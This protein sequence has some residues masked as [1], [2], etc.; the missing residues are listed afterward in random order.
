MNKN[1]QKHKQTMKMNHRTRGGF[2]LVELLVVIVIIAAL[3][4]LTAPMVIKQRKKADQ[5]EAVNNARQIGLALFQFDTDYASYPDSETAQEVSDRTGSSLNMGGTTANDYFR[6][7]I[8]SKVTDQES[9]FFAKIPGARKPDN[10]ISGSEALKQGEVGFAYLTNNNI[11]L[12]SG[13]N[14]ARPIVVTP[15]LNNSTTGQFD[16]GP[17][18]DK[19]IVLRMDNSVT[20]LD[21]RQDNNQI[22]LGGSN[23]SLLTTGQD[24]VWGPLDGSVTIRT[25]DL[26]GGSGGGGGSG[27]SGGGGA[28]SRIID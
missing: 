13:G 22:N 7:L 26:R 8:A 16:P 27:G 3:A 6:Q 25:P 20:S 19:A 15:L 14:S 17:F 28:G 1:P 21:I 18:E 23:S 5:T 9:M 12:S 2:T 24:T 4:G 11:A 10:N